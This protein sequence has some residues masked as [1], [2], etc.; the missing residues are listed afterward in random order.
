[1]LGDIPDLGVEA[2]EQS[3]AVPRRSDRVLGFVKEMTCAK[4]IDERDGVYVVDLESLRESSGELGS[5][6]RRLA[7]S[8]NGKDD[9]ARVIEASADQG[10]DE[11]S[12]QRVLRLPDSAGGEQ[13]SVSHRW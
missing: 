13:G 12:A 7:P 4:V 6:E 1:V 5:R 8:D 10:P 11:K 9:P 2:L 3:S